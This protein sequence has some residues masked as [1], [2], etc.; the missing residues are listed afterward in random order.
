MRQN[1]D[2]LTANPI[3]KPSHSLSDY[4]GFFENPGYGRMQIYLK[5]DTLFVE[6]N[7]SKGKTY[8]SHYHYDVFKARST[9]APED[10]SDGDANKVRFITNNKGEIGTLETQM[11]P[12]VKD[13]VFTGFP[14]LKLEKS[15]LQKYTGDYELSGTSVK[16]YLKGDSTLMIL[17]TG[18]PDYEM[19]PTKKMN[20]I[21][22][23]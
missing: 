18:Q 17:V 8:L 15:E 20:L 14:A 22:K 13:I 23:R 7:N 21:L 3:Q 16:V 6:Y 19:V 1:T 10:A 2:I 4:T 5:N 12:A 9:D 11:E